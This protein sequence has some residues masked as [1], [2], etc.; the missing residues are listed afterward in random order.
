[1]GDKA[2]TDKDVKKVEFMFGDI[3]KVYPDDVTFNGDNFI[4]PLT[5]EETFSFL[6][7]L[8]YKYQ[9]RILFNDSS[10]KRTDQTE[11]TVVESQSKEVL[12]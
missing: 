4:V 3:K 1:M 10:V 8:I 12:V 5:Q 9:A 2:V 6:P 11:F 7:Q